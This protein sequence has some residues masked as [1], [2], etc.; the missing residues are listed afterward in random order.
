M[1]QFGLVLL[2]FSTWAFGQGGVVQPPPTARELHHGQQ[3][4]TPSDL[5]CSGFITTQTIP[6]SSYVAA[7]WNSPDQTHYAGA[8][9]FVYIYGASSF[10]AGDRLHILR[11][12]RDP[13]HY[14]L[15]KGER[16]A[17]QQVGQPYFERGYVRV[18]EVQRNVAIAVPELSCGDFVPGD[19][20]IPLV[21][22]EKPVLHPVTLDRFAVANG[23]PTGRIVMTNEFDS[24]VG[25]GQKVYLNIGEDKGLKVGDYL[26]ATRTYPY[27]YRDPV[28]G[29]STYA[30]NTEETQKKP[31]KLPKD[32][33]GDLPRRTLGAMV[34]LTVH[35][36]SAT[37]M[38]VN[39]LEDI[40]AGDGVEVMDEQ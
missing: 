34:V 1:K 40:H 29:L 19:V 25:S 21:E 11:K 27:S 39:A 16:A 32:K 15:Y 33:L 36:R 8:T 30:T 24:V 20:A 13:N 2:V 31:P 18:L 26:R 35:P 22:R 10:K 6:E 17:I 14:E 37:A 12:V 23:K 38:I 7:G 4:V 3:L 9:D 28:D 5:Y